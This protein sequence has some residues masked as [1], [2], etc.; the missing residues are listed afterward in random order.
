MS[1]PGKRRRSTLSGYVLPAENA[2]GTPAGLALVTEWEEEFFLET[3]KSTET[4]ADLVEQPVEIS[5]DWK[6]D[7]NE[8]PFFLVRSFKHIKD[9]LGW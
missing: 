3:T 6:E 9:D 4:L 2:D 8:E 1:Q 5:G 7:D